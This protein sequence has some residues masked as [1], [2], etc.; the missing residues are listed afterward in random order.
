M[1]SYIYN[2]YINIYLL[3]LTDNKRLHRFYLFNKEVLDFLFEI[4]QIVKVA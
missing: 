3:I 1:R 4:I 2:A